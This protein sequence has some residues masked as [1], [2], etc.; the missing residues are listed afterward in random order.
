MFRLASFVVL[1]LGTEPEATNSVTSFT[2]PETDHRGLLGAECPWRLI[3][4]L[5]VICHEVFCV[6]GLKCLIMKKKGSI[7]PF[8]MIWAAKP[9]WH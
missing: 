9:I 6:G 8:F 3:G 2:V 5:S 7:V 1:V 4:R